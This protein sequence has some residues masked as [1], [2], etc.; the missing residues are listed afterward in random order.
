[1]TSALS[2]LWGYPTSSFQDMVKSF[3]LTWGSNRGPFD[4][5]PSS[6]P[7]DQSGISTEK[8]LNRLLYQRI[9]YFIRQYGFDQISVDQTFFGLRGKCQNINIGLKG[10]LK[11]CLKV[12]IKVGLKIG[13]NDQL[14]KIN[15]YKFFLLAL[16]EGSRSWVRILWSLH[17]WWIPSQVETNYNNN[18]NMFISLSL[19]TFYNESS[20]HSWLKYT[21][22]K[23]I[24]TSIKC[25][26]TCKYKLHK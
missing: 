4:C 23:Y 9:K 11:V 18:N 15:C 26:K 6:L 8:I 17:S 25:K 1:M 13:L 7:L 20:L 3:R 2:Y 5:E 24:Y 12:G 19:Y 14:T 10:G 16:A 21:L 22:L